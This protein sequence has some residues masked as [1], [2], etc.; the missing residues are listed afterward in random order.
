MSA[1]HPA[2]SRDDRPIDRCSFSND[3]RYFTRWS[4]AHGISSIRLWMSSHFASS[5][6]SGV[7][8]LA[9]SA[10]SERPPRTL[11]SYR[12]RVL[13]TGLT[14]AVAEG[15]SGKVARGRSRW[16]RGRPGEGA[17][18]RPYRRLSASRNSRGV[19]IRTPPNR[20]SSSRWWSPVTIASAPAA[21][22]H[23]RIRLSASSSRTTLTGCRG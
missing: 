5:S 21:S 22:A 11:P 7:P 13:A 8:S 6:T 15:W 2:A 4:S 20:L 17:V 1:N 12:R 9:P 16:R 3:A 23:S 18:G 10:M 19:V 14:R